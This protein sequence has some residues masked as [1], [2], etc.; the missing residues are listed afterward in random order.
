MH[1]PYHSGDVI[2]L[3]SS[4]GYLIGRVLPQQPQGPWWEYIETQA[5]LDYA[6]ARA[7][8]LAQPLLARAWIFDGIEYRVIQSSNGDSNGDSLHKH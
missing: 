8:A 1:Q 4:H 5:A 2:V 7:Q 3:P 6:M